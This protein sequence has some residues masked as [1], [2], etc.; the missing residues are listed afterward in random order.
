MSA[1]TTSVTPGGPSSGSGAPITIENL[2]APGA[3]PF[4]VILPMV[5]GEL[6]RQSAQPVLMPPAAGLDPETLTRAAALLPPSP[7]RW[8]AR[9]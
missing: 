8:A 1:E 4:P 2:F 9:A 3:Q 5:Q 6:I 7:C